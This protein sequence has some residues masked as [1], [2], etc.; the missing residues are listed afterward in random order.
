MLKFVLASHGRLAEGMHDSICLILGESV[1]LHTICAYTQGPDDIAKEVRELL[2]S[3]AKEDEVIVM[4]DLFGG[5]IISAF[6]QLLSKR[7]FWLVTGVNLGLAAE[8][9]LI[10]NESNIEEKINEAI[11]NSRRLMCLYNSFVTAEEW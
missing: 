5:R 7:K 11:E 9:L 3:F 1:K 10:D 8:L 2:D 6:A 4:T